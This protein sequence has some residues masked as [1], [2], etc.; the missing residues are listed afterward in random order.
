MIEEP[1]KQLDCVS[2]TFDLETDIGV[3]IA[4]PYILDLLNKYDISAT[5]FITA[6]I[7]EKY[8]LDVKGI[9]DYGHEIGCHGLKHENLEKAPF[10]EIS[11]IIKDSM[12][13]FKKL[14]IPLYSFR[15]PYAK[16]SN[17]I[18]EVL[19]YFHFRIDSSIPN[20]CYSHLLPYHPSKT[21]W[22]AL[23]GE[24]DYFRVLEIPITSIP[25]QIAFSTENTYY[26][27]FIPFIWR[28][29]KKTENLKIKR[30]SL[31]LKQFINNLGYPSILVF[32]FHPWEFVKCKNNSIAINCLKKLEDL[33]KVFCKE[34]FEFHSLY[35]VGNIWEKNFC[36]IHSKIKEVNDA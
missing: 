17:D 22:G 3:K 18:F 20:F 21:D 6:E 13:I 12:S 27:G 4:L 9:I 29:V 11:R 14:N 5:F 36:P 19:D 1:T 28:V 10:E 26:Y 25:I 8:P 30:Y 23:P 7:I 34:E 2:L 24:N 31:Q 32:N 16:P 15:A 33:I 35:E